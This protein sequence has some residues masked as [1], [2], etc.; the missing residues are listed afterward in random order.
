MNDFRQSDIPLKLI[1]YSSKMVS[2]LGTLVEGDPKAH[3]SI[4]T[5]PMCRG[6]HNSIPWIVPLYP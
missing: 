5:T 3:F 4:A 6:G 1:I 2:K